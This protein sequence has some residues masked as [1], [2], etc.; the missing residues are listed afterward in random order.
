MPPSGLP[1]VLCI[2]IPFLFRLFSGMISHDGVLLGEVRLPG[3]SLG[4]SVQLSFIPCTVPSTLRDRLME[5]RPSDLPVLH[6]VMHD[7]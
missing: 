4:A 1:A 7:S 6:D 3:R 2:H 5:L